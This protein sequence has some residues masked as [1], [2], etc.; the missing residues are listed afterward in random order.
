VGASSSSELSI[1]NAL[2]SP[3]AVAP[4][5][6]TIM[7]LPGEKPSRL[8][9]RLA[10]AVLPER[11]VGIID[12]DSCTR[13]P[14]GV[15]ESAIVNTLEGKGWPQYAGAIGSHSSVTHSTAAGGSSLPGSSLSL[16]AVSRS[17]IAILR[18]GG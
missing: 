10:S 18:I 6:C 3:T 2:G 12:S 8:L 9:H 1:V 5:R 11:V 7:P 17:A 4:G 16:H 15:L 13:R 14:V